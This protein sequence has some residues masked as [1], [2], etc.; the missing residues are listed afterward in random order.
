MG[1]TGPKPSCECND[2]VNCQTCRRRERSRLH[3]HGQRLP[4]LPTW[5]VPREAA[6]NLPTD[7]ADIAYIA[8]L[9]DGEGCITEN[10]KGFFV[11]QIGMTDEPVIR[12][13]ARL[14]GTVRIEAGPNRGNR[15][16]LY[17]WRLMAANDVQAFLRAIHPYLRVKQSA[18]ENAIVAIDGR[19]L[20]KAGAA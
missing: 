11:A 8:G 14:G 1:R 2:F 20:V 5:G 17:R 9:F 15:K 6:L 10:G 12:W 3:Y 19:Q 4:T 16:P 7:I 18:A 13:V